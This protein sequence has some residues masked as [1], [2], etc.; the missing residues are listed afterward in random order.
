MEQSHN[1]IFIN[2]LFLL[3][4]RRE[5]ESVQISLASAA[6]FERNRRTEDLKCSI[7]NTNRWISNS[8]GGHAARFFSR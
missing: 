2:H 5:A 4:S 8:V 6:A 1:S 7:F 3:E